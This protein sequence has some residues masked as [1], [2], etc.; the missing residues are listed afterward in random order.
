MK[1]ILIT[2]SACLCI[3]AQ[4][5]SAA[6][7]GPYTIDP[8]G[9]VSTVTSAS[10]VLSTNGAD[11]IT[12]LELTTYIQ[13]TTTGGSLGLGFN[14][15]LFNNT[16]DD[17]VF[18]FVRADSE[19]TSSFFDLSINGNTQVDVEASLFTFIDSDSGLTKKYQIDFGNGYADML[20]ATIEL[21]DFGIT[22]TD[23]I[24]E[25]TISN[26]GST[27]RLALAA[28][29]NLSANA[30]AEVPLPAAVWLFITGLGALGMI[31]R[32]RR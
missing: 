3:H 8:A 31:S 29:F 22:G 26:L 24:N 2:I 23:F 21:G 20:I 32:R 5:A 12:D 19:P 18:Y 6:T 7:I 27:D 1:K 4:S 10:N 13:G 9:S 14:N 16:G 15:S 28:G 30:P 11:A 25:L 17:I